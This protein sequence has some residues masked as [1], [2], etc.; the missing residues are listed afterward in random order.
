MSLK[1]P[2]GRR[3][4]IYAVA[5]LLSAGVLCPLF[6]QRANK[7]TPRPG[8][9]PY[10][11]TKLE[12]ATVELQANDGNTN[13]TSDSPVMISFVAQPDG[14]TVLCILQYTPEVPAHVVKINRDAS[15]YAFNKYRTSRGWDWLRLKF[16]E[17]VISR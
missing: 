16:D 1:M 7:T 4:L 10:T 9:E 13:Y 15:R 6:A 17:H 5:M 11:P 12:W 3:V 2:R 8:D 14:Q